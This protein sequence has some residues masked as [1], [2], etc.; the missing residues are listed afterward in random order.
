MQ[1]FTGTSLPAIESSHSCMSGIPVLYSLFLTLPIFPL[2]IHTVGGLCQPVQAMLCSDWFCCNISSKY[3]I[4]LDVFPL[5]IHTVGGYVMLCACVSSSQV[6]CAHIPAQCSL[7]PTPGAFPHSSPALITGRK[8]PGYQ[9]SS[10]CKPC[11]AVTGFVAI[12]VQNTKS[13][14]TYFLIQLV[15]MSCCVPV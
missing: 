6:A 2:P 11:L 4:P 5:P 13:H 7:D 9:A 1:T 12:S 14:L 10:W 3:Q 8:G 15:G